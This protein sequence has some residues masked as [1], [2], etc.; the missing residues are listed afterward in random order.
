MEKTMAD[1]VAWFHAIPLLIT[2]PL[3]IIAILVAVAT[4]IRMGNAVRYIPN[5]SVGV[6][7]KIWSPHGSIISGFIALHSEAGFQPDV[8]RG[9]FHFFRPFMYKVHVQPL[10]MIGQ[11]KVGYV[12]ARD[13]QPLEPSQTLASNAEA[14]D[15]IMFAGSWRQVARRGRSASCCAKARMRSTSLN[16][17]CLPR[18]RPTRSSSASRRLGS[19]TRCAR[20]SRTAKGSH[21]S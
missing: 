12:Y 19:S 20:Q 21:Q 14:G 4:V 1:F 3:L 16:S 13:G 11:G 15:F 6:V 10:V 5:D 7:E 17:S 8:L 2:I 9:G 18:I